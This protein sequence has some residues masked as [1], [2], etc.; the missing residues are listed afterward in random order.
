MRSGRVGAPEARSGNPDE[1]RRLLVAAMKRYVEQELMLPPAPPDRPARSTARTATGEPSTAAGL[2]AGDAGEGRVLAGDRVIPHPGEAPRSR[3][4]EL[5]EVAASCAACTACAL[6]GTRHKAV[7]GTGHA[8]ARLML[9]GE[10]P[11]EDED[12]SGL[13]FVGAAGKLLTK[14]LAAIHL[15]RDEVF[16]TNIVK[17]RPPGNRVPHENEVAACRGYLERQIAIIRPSLIVS[18]GGPA[19]KFFL[20]DPE[21]KITKIHGQLF[22]WRSIPL[23][24]TLHPAYLLRTNAA[25][26]DAWEDLKKVREFLS[27]KTVHARSGKAGPGAEGGARTGAPGTAPPSDSPHRPLE[28]ADDTAQAKEPSERFLSVPP[29]TTS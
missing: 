5:Q 20:E 8:A 11:G 28:H 22:Q 16:I 23:I 18:L 24:P 12:E 10:G 21:L 17:C 25:K 1:A 6:A 26:K 29:P 14:M 9:V 7:P 19:T 27:V 2:G 4:E 15:T 13:P 3:I